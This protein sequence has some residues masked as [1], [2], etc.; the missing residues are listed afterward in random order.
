MIPRTNNKDIVPDADPTSCSDETLFG[1]A[2]AGDHAAFATLVRRYERELYGYLRRYLGDAT[3]AD[4][5]F[6]NTFVALHRKREQYE[7]GRPFRPWLY[8]VATN[9][10]IDAMRRAG[11]HAAMSL[12]RA[13]ADDAGDLGRLLESL[14]AREIQPLAGV[15]GEE[16]R[17]L[18]RRSVDELPEFLKQVVLLTYFQGLKYR[19]AADVLGI[20]VG[21]VKSRLHAALQ[22]LAE[23]WG[24]CPSLRED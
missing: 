16:L 4:D 18:V 14:E 21:T 9:Q 11:R 5:V 8:A 12:E 10:A 19:D 15:E 1:R 17:E 23:A 6:Q 22:K 2:R 3:L 13:T 20:P 7:P 24:E